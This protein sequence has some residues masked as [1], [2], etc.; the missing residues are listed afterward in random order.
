MAVVT[1]VIVK[2]KSTRLSPHYHN[3]RPF[4]V[5]MKENNVINTNIMLLLIFG[6]I[7]PSELVLVGNEFWYYCGK[8]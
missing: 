1:I 6:V 3:V 7:I 8:C 2:D 4:Y 5:K